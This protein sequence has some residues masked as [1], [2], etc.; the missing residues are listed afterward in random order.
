MCDLP[1]QSHLEGDHHPPQ[2]VQVHLEVATP[3]HLHHKIPHMSTNMD[4]SPRKR[5]R[6]ETWVPSEV[7]EA[8]LIPEPTVPIPITYNTQPPPH[9]SQVRTQY[10]V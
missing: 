7:I 5:T 4:Q 8:F 9:S 6:S 3:T 1:P 10:S 2:S